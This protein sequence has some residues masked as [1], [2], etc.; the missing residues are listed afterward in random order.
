MKQKLFSFMCQNWKNAII[1]ILFIAVVTLMS[2]V[3]LHVKADNFEID[4]SQSVQNIQHLAT[5]AEQ[6]A[7]DL[8]NARIAFEQC[9][10]ALGVCKDQRS[11]KWVLDQ[12]KADQTILYQSLQKFQNHV[13]GDY[14]YHW[15]VEIGMSMK[16]DNKRVLGVNT[17]KHLVIDS[18]K[19][20]YNAIWELEPRK[21]S[22]YENKVVIS[23]NGD[24]IKDFDLGALYEVIGNNTDIVIRNDSG[25]NKDW[26]KGNGTV[27]V[28]VS[29][30]DNLVRD[31]LVVDN[32]CNNQ[33][34][35][36]EFVH[37]V[38]NYY[39]EVQKEFS[40]ELLRVNPDVS[41]LL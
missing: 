11:L 19:N 18:A 8:E 29:L 23:L 32:K 39:R 37:L 15:Y 41:Q 1:A 27:F 6:T 22:W 30:K 9:T 20:R 14:A 21:I 13:K 2:R 10:Q 12:R 34:Q 3:P 26:S 24:S 35:A 4:L 36:L 40:A 38:T 16:G 31:N 7:K 28:P 33:N 5:V 25:T 17:D